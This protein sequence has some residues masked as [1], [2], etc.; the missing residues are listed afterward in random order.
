[1]S[2]AAE[3]IDLPVFA[4]LG[5]SDQNTPLLTATYASKWRERF[6]AERYD[7]ID[8]IYA[9]ARVEALPFTWSATEYE[10][11]TNARQRQMFDEAAE[12]GLTR[13]ITVPLRQTE[14][15]TSHLTFAAGEDSKAFER[16]VQ[17]NRHYIHLLAL[18]FDA[19]IV[20]KLVHPSSNG[21]YR[22]GPKLSARE[23]ECLRWAMRGK[24][25][26]ETAVILSI[27]R[28]TVVFHLENVRRKLNVTTTR[29]A[30]VEGIRQGVVDL[31][32]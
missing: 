13:G 16:N 19:N 4:Y 15:G 28:R 21:P 24:S 22:L 20:S 9:K 29:R 6:L 1:M 7:R 18:H 17:E 31:G 5:W 2:R 11:K 26:Y 12:F 10:G 32:G 23:V 14:G 8:P 3:A 27:S 25:S 30:I